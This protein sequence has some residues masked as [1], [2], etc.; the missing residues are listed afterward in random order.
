M[1]ERTGALN[2]GAY[3]TLFFVLLGIVLVLCYHFVPNGLYADDF[4]IKYIQ[5]R[6]FCINDWKSLSLV[7]PAKD[8]DPEYT[9]IGTHRK[10]LLHNGRL[11][12]SYQVLLPFMT[13]FLYPFLGERCV[14]FFPLLAFW[15]G[16]LFFYKIMRL[17]KPKYALILTIIYVCVNPTSLYAITFW[18]H[19]P[20]L[21]FLVT[22]LYLFTR[23]VYDDPKKIRYMVAGSACIALTI[24]FRTECYGLIVAF[25]GPVGLYFLL[26]KR[27]R[28]VAAIVAGT[29]FVVGLHCAVNQWLYGTIFGLHVTCN[30]P[31]RFIQF[32]KL[33]VVIA[34]IGTWIWLSM[35]SRRS[36]SDQSFDLLCVLLWSGYIVLLLQESVTD[37]VFIEYPLSIFLLWFYAVKA[38]GPDQERFGAYDVNTLLK[39]FFIVF[40]IFMT[41]VGILF[42]RNPDN[43][44]RYLLPMIPFVMIAIGIRFEDI[45]KR[46]NIFVVFIF[47]CIATIGCVVFRFRCD[48]L[49]FKQLNAERTTFIEEFTDDGDIIVFTRNSLFEHAGLKYFDR[50]ML[51]ARNNDEF[52]DM[53]STFNARGVETFYYMTA[54]QALPLDLLQHHGNYAITAK[55][56]FKVYDLFTFSRLNV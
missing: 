13:S 27:W 44:V 30:P 50:R 37:R 20:L 55:K 46:K 48:I 39:L 12:S 9:F 54:S 36:S 11:I 19:V 43:N 34:F 56:T 33:V 5:M 14:L 40:I 53:L 32:D 29:G 25:L 24:F 8:L 52:A 6:S 18:D 26:K 17:L 2:A 22:G 10:W 47:L 16:A 1:R 35:T 7:Y 3:A 41:L 45:I 4:G 51:V 42:Y 49:Y 23:S 21:A 31:P 38:E 28:E 15:V